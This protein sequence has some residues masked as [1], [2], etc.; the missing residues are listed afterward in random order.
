[1]RKLIRPSVVAGVFVALVCAT[2]ISSAQQ[3]GERRAQRGERAGAAERG[4]RGGRGERG[5]WNPEQM[6]QRMMERFQEVLGAT[7]Q[8]WQ[9]MSPFVAQVMEK[10]RDL[11]AYS[12]RGWGFRGRG[13]PGG[14]R[15]PGRGFG[16]ESPQVVTDLQEALT[17]NASPDEIKTK[18][19]A[20][21]NARGAAEK[22]LQQAQEKLRQVLTIQQE[23]NL[24]MM[25]ILD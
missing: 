15:G 20:Y 6:Q 5:R 7:D 2:V 18:L 14:D 25:G 3:R 1:M 21:R 23:A 4:D 17:S 22:D 9:V 16:G 11:R 8:E 13:G 24:V 10:Q 19:T 12:G